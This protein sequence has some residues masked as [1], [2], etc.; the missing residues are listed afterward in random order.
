MQ[1]IIPCMRVTTTCIRRTMFRMKD[2]MP[3]MRTIMRPDRGM[4]FV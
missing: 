2:I 1:R 4:S 3:L